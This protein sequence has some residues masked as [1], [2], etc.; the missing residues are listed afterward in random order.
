MGAYL[1]MPKKKVDLRLSRQ[2]GFDLLGAALT[3]RVKKGEKDITEAKR[4]IAK[5][6]KG[7]KKR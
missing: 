6:K 2:S 5:R 7:L 1:L 4:Q 3:R